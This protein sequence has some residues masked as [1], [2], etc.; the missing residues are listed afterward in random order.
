MGRAVGQRPVG[1]A[2]QLDDNQFCHLVQIEPDGQSEVRVKALRNHR[3]AVQS[4]VKSVC[5]DNPLQ[6]LSRHPNANHGR[7]GA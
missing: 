5:A 1:F 3:R 6:C 2:R 7:S 4:R